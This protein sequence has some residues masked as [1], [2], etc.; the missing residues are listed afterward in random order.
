MSKHT[1]FKFAES[2]EFLDYTWDDFVGMCIAELIL[3]IPTGKF[4]ERVNWVLAQAVSWNE[5]NHVSK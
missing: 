5:Y 2:S 1:L 4:N 3:S